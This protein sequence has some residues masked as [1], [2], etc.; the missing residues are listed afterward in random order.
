MEV[1]QNI[2]IRVPVTLISNTTGLP[3]TGITYSQ[4]TVYLQKQSSSAASKSMTVTDWYEISSVNMPGEYD[5]V[6]STS[7]VDTLGFLKYYASS[8][9]SQAY[10]GL[11]EVVANIASDI[12][13]VALRTQG[14]VFD[15]IYED[16]HIY[17]GTTGRLTSAR[18]RAYDTAAHASL[19]GATGLLYTYAIATT[20]DVSGNIDSF[21]CIRDD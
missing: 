19:H 4:I 6:L 1:K 14:L 20:Y 3:I 21:S 11:I 16:N 12:Y 2:S 5:L 7:D 10:R 17:D 18:I 8:S 13:S 9:G 15:N